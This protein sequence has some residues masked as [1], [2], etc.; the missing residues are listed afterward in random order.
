ML[1]RSPRRRRPALSRRPAAVR[2]VAVGRRWV[3]KYSFGRGFFLRP[4]WLNGAGKCGDKEFPARDENSNEA[5]RL[6][7]SLSP[8]STFYGKAHKAVRCAKK[9][10]ILFFSA[11]KFC[12]Y[13]VLRKTTT[14][15]VCIRKR[16]SIGRK[17]HENKLEASHPRGR[18]PRANSG[19]NYPQ[20]LDGTTTL[21]F[22]RGP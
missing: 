2:S 14:M 11:T 7:L 19:S 18:G 5:A 8:Q 1:H 16:R 4:L 22:V 13:T 21:F 12:Q 10:K 17:A 6:S 9:F 15:A 20:K 3:Y